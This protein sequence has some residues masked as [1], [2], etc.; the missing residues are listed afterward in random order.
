MTSCF[1]CA[2]F[3]SMAWPGRVPGSWTGET[4]SW[5]WPSLLQLITGG[6]QRRRGTKY[7]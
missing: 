2:S 3:S 5:L 6:G 4:V 7:S 1:F